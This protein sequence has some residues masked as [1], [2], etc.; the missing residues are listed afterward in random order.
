M[1]TLVLYGSIAG[2]LT[3]IIVLFAKIWGVVN[4]VKEMIHIWKS[5]QEFAN[6]TRMC[7]LRM[8]IKDERFPLDERIEAGKKYV[9]HGWNGSTKA[10]VEMM[11]QV[12][13]EE[14]EK[15]VR[16]TL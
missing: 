11:E 6:Y 2:A 4:S 5:D 8:F 16:G 9:D 13:D 14:I 12:R 15:K 3:A 1:E 7:S 10:W